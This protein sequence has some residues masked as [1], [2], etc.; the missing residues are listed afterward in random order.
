MPEITDP[1]LEYLFKC[2]V[3]GNCS[4][5]EKEELLGWIGQA[6]YDDQL[7]SLMDQ[8]WTR[9]S[10]AYRLDE[11]QSERILSGILPPRSVPE[12]RFS[13]ILF[14][15]WTGVAAAILVLIAVAW[16]WDIDSPEKPKENIPGITAQSHNHQ[17]IGGGNKAVLILGNGSSVLLDSAHNGIIAQQGGIAVSKANGALS[18][19]GHSNGNQE[20]V[21]NT[22]VTPPGGQYRVVLP[23]GSKVWLNA[24]SSL[25]FPTAFTDTTRRV[26]LAGEAYFEVAADK[27][28]PFKINV[29][30]MEVNVLGTHFNI[31]AYHDEPVIR[32]TLLE[33]SVRVSAGNKQ[34][35]LSPGQ[36][37]SVDQSGAGNIEVSKA[38]VQAAV[39]WKEGLFLFHDTNISS[40]LREIARWYDAD[41]VY[42]G[43]VNGRLNGMI[44]RQAGLQEVLHMLEVTSNLKFAIEGKVIVVEAGQ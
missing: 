28:K 11:T 2:Y 35:V 40:V 41:V 33:G 44:S 10:S 15:R 9:L 20:I 38:D 27:E 16:L 29:S 19:S 43:N 4:Q 23:D 17:I 3:D 13:S 7:K 39:A 5:A 36:Q 30:G 37:A 24:T 21:Y 22:I 1:R 12:K 42:Q 31:M 18:Y 25:R 14:S 34:V 26:E 8:V 6:Q 32:T